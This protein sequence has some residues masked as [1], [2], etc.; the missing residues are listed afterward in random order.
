[1]ETNLT[2]FENWI[3]SVPEHFDVLTWR[4]EELDLWPL[5]KTALVGLA[6]VAF[7]GQR[8]LGLATGGIGWQVGVFADYFMSPII[9]NPFGFPCSAPAPA[10]G[11]SKTVLCFD[12]GGHARDLG[13][14]LV[15]P[16][17]D[18]AAALLTRSGHRPVFWFESCVAADPKLQNA[19]HGPA[20]GIA[21]IMGF[22]RKRALRFG[23]QK[24]L[25]ALPGYVECCYVAA[26]HLG[27]SVRF[28]KFWLT[29]QVN[30][31]ISAGWCFERIFSRHGSPELLLTTNSC[32]WNT[33]GLIATAKRR[34]IPVIENSAWR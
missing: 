16:S 32:V 5:F 34:G 25:N 27:I 26:Q 21:D 9:R 20:Y 8:R 29:R 15:S 1:M 24:A 30:L 31:A 3:A 14:L 6:V 23:T 22:A 12:S 28:L 10:E 13:G 18:V 7:M 11:L 2:K 4:H 19:I 17:L 33:S